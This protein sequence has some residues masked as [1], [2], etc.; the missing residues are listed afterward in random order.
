ML[1]STQFT[2]IAL[3]TLTLTACLK[4]APIA[5]GQQHPQYLGTWYLHDEQSNA[6]SHHFKSVLFEI[7]GDGTATYLK[8]IIV[9]DATGNHKHSSRTQVLNFQPINWF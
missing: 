7:N 4:D 8:C 3:L 5:M 1:P 9:N 2:I 6:D